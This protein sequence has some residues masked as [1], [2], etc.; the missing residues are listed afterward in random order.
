MNHEGRHA[1]E[2]AI[3][4]SLEYYK[5]N[6]TDFFLDDRRHYKVLLEQ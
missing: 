4:A 6:T 3:L 5:K 1:N 2:C